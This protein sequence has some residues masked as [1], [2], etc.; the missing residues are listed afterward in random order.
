[1]NKKKK[2]KKGKSDNDKRAVMCNSEKR[3]IQ[4]EDRTQVPRYSAEPRSST[5]SRSRVIDEDEGEIKRR[6]ASF[7][8]FLKKNRRGGRPT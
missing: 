7:S 1:M 6:P 8:V 4:K 2:V 3:E 5:W